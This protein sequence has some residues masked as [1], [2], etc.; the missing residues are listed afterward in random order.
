MP[1][2]PSAWEG[3]AHRLSKLSQESAQCL[4]QAPIDCWALTVL[5]L[6]T[7]A[8]LSVNIILIM[9]IATGRIQTIMAL[10]SMSA[11]IIP[12]VIIARGAIQTSMLMS[13]NPYPRQLW[14]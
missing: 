8:T 4:H 13:R 1:A 14:H 6:Q 2:K 3:S 12:I 10:V 7:L 5:L 9:S 11:T